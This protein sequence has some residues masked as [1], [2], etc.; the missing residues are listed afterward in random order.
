MKN[1]TLPT[2]FKIVG[3]VVKAYN[4]NNHGHIIHAQS[5][6]RSTQLLLL[7]LAACDSYLVVSTR[8]I[9]QSYPQFL[10]SLIRPIYVELP[11]IA[12]V[13]SDPLIWFEHP[14]HSVHEAEAHRSNKFHSH[15]TARLNIKVATH[16]SCLLQTPKLFSGNELSTKL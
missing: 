7:S 14:L 4:D 15:H 6:Q 13:P 12:N 5:E 9:I 1:K 11:K 3:P 16:H 2:L 10:T 8:D